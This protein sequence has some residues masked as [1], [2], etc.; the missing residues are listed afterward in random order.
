MITDEMK[1]TENYRMYAAM[2]GVDVPTTQSQPIKS[3]QGTHRTTSA[4]RTPNPDVDEEESSA[5]RKSTVIRLRIPPRRS[6]RLIPPTPIPTTQNVQKVEEHLIAEEIEKLVEGTKNVML[7]VL[8]LGEMIIKM[9]PTLE[10]DESAEDDYKLKRREKGRRYLFENLKTR[11]MPRKKFH[12]LAQ[13]LQEVMEE[14]LPKMVDTRV[15]E[16]TKIQVPI[17][18]AQG[19][20]MERK[21][22]QADVKHGYVTPSLS[23][24]YAEYLQL[25]EEEIK[26][27]LKH[28]DQ[29]RR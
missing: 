5:P 10:E 22:N 3:T 27:P 26:E 12:V 16:L 6:T 17:Y 24:E 18:V 11:F 21:Q 13:H 2:F 4:P 19:L 25:F 1:L 7:I 23:K 15:Q 14:S 28:R 9:I 8:P 20:I 29:M